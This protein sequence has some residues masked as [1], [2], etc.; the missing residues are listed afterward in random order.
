VG[1]RSSKTRATIQA[2]QNEIPFGGRGA[3]QLK[4]SQTV[5]LLD[6]KLPKYLKEALI[7][8]DKDKEIIK[9]F[10]KEFEQE[11]KFLKELANEANTN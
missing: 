4:L 3:E 8:A 10:N 6:Y 5:M 7:Q 1:S 11:D 2:K 9:K